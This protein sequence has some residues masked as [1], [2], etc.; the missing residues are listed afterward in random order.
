VNRQFLYDDDDVDDDDH[1]DADK[2]ISCIQTRVGLHL[3]SFVC[4]I[5]V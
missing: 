1:A 2:L 3:S 5:R 4:V